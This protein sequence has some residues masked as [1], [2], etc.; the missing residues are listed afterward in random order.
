MSVCVCVCVCVNTKCEKEYEEIYM[1]ILGL[2][3]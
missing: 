3:K 2:N 1:K